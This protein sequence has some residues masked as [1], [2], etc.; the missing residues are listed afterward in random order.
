LWNGVFAGLFL[1]FSLAASGLPEGWVRIGVCAA[2]FFRFLFLVLLLAKI[3][4][5]FLRRLV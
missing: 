2:A 4:L 5:F 3:V 1:P